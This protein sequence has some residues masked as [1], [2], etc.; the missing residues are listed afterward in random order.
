[1]IVSP[2]RVVR[3]DSESS[4]VPIQFPSVAMLWRSVTQYVDM[5]MIVLKFP[6]EFTAQSDL[7]VIAKLPLVEWLIKNSG[8]RR[9]ILQ[10]VEAAQCQAKAQ[11]D[12]VGG[13][14]PLIQEQLSPPCVLTRCKGW[15]SSLGV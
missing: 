1:M 13:K 14:G 3:R 11:M 10:V 2:P 5:N 8:L 15:G 7:N 9:T 4:H 12:S 6:Q